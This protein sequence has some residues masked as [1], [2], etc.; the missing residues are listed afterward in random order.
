MKVAATG[1]RPSRL[2]NEYDY[3]GPY[4]AYI[5]SELHKLLR[6]LKP[7][8][9]I[10]GMALGFDTIF[11]LAALNSDTPLIAAIPFEGQESKW[12]QKSQ[13]LYHNIL[14]DPL[15]TQEYI[16]EPGYAAWKMHK[17]DQ[18]MVD[19][20]DHLIAVWDGKPKG[21]T[22]STIEYAKKIKRPYTIINPNRWKIRTKIVNIKK[23]DPYDI[24]IG[25][26]SRWGNPFFEG[27]RQ[28]NIEKYRE[29]VCGRQDL[30]NILSELIGKRLGCFCAPL[31]CHGDV[32][33]ELMLEHEIF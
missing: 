32:L 22:F 21:G 29:Y 8:K 28:E 1:H 16:C 12:F 3:D 15:T 24:Y 6:Q 18:W 25:R 19:E 9:M 27:S 20:C 26:G 14:N 30:I 11:A 10:S 23:N 13:E 31:P 4:T 5:R 33:I 17:R 2:G 7:N